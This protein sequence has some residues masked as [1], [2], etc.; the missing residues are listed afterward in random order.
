MCKRGHYLLALSFAFLGALCAL[1]QDAAAMGG[2][3][4]EYIGSPEEW[5]Q[6]QK[7]LLNGIYDDGSGPKKITPALLG[8]VQSGPFLQTDSKKRQWVVMTTLDE[9]HCRLLK[10]LRSS[11]SATTVSTNLEDISCSTGRG[12]RS[13]ADLPAFEGYGE[14][15]KAG[16]QVLQSLAD[17]EWVAARDC[18]IFGSEETSLFSQNLILR[19]QHDLNEPDHGQ[20]DEVGVDTRAIAFS[21]KSTEVPKEIRLF[22]AQVRILREMRQADGSF[23]FLIWAD[24]FHFPT[25]VENRLQFAIVNPVLI[26]SSKPLALNE[27]HQ[28]C[29]GETCYAP[30]ELEL[31]LKISP[32]FVVLEYNPKS[33]LVLRVVLNQASPD[34]PL[35]DLTY[36][37]MGLQR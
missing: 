26:A 6:A 1:S 30:N 35:I 32:R 33:P 23:R 21:K 27:K 10:R 37:R 12:W 11:V 20:I 8:K 5:A 2:K 17:L 15:S 25:E 3:R 4:L 7:A 28:I 14:L 9:D 29:V 34:A 24:R 22:P 16:R 18:T 31:T 19:L 13:D 36:W